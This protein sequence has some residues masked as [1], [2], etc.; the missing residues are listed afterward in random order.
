MDIRPGLLIKI[1]VNIDH[2]KEVSDVRS[3]TVFDII[4]KKLIIAQTEPPILK[5]KINKTVILTYLTKE[6]K[7]IVRYGFDAVIV[8]LI[9][10]YELSTDHKT[11]AVILLKK[12]NPVQNNLRFF[13]RVEPL[14]NSD[15]YMSI[16]R[17]PVNILDIS[18][19]GAKISHSREFRLQSG[20]IIG[21]R[22]SIDNALFDINAVIV[23]TWDPEEER[24]IKSLEFVALEFI[25]TSIHFKNALGKKILEIQGELRSR[26]IL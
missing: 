21:I 25:N 26:G 23:R 16:Y 3:S 6:N 22:L 17:K 13:F 9:K 4:E 8:D 18:I 2:I 12:T 1:V 14:S 7:D 19:G 10:S 24:M 15:I 5:S 11:Q 20:G